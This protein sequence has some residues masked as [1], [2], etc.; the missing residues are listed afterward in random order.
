VQLAK[1]RGVPVFQP[2][3]LRSGPFPDAWAALGLDVAVVVAYGRILPPALL[4]APR[5]GCVNVHASLLP[6]WRG[7]AP[8]QWAIASGD[9]ETGVTTM[10]M[11]EGLD[12]GPILLQRATSIGPEETATDLA[13]RLSELGT[14]LLLETLA[15][16]D[17]IVPRPQEAALA[18]RAPPLTREDGRVDWTLG[19]RA[20]DARVRGL[21]P[22]PGVWTTFRGEVLRI[23][24]VRPADV[25]P[26]GAAPGTVLEARRRLVVAA[27]D[28]ALELVVV[29][30]GCH[31]AQEG[32]AW[33]CGT[34]IQP[35]EVIP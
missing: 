31:R 14:G 6:R 13:L 11:D 10:R 32:P 12:T 21:T 22:W 27:G 34:R 18:T 8:I 17:R 16:L 23:V 5:R 4:A 19:A 3:A 26:H 24:Q 15:G 30:S 28:G 35:G 9:A 7:A 29:Q 25:D 2:R 1:S 33:C 20:I